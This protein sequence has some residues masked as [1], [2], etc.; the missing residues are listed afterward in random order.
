MSFLWVGVLIGV[1]SLALSYFLPGT[2]LKQL[3]IQEISLSQQRHPLGSHHIFPLV[4][5]PHHEIT[6]KGW[7]E[8]LTNYYQDIEALLDQHQAILFRNF[9]ISSA[10]DFHEMVEATG[11]PSMDY[12]GG[13][14]VRKQ[15]T[16]R[17]VSSNESPPSE[18]IPFH[19]EMA[20]TPHPP[21][22]G[23][24]LILNPQ[25]K[26]LICDQYYSLVKSSQTPEEKHLY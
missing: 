22:H 13:A 18:V 21:T 2:S 6:L 10:Q 26:Y 23:E 24:N 15:F 14:A 4:L 1:I 11:L 5:K 16:S 20:Q 19:H 25:C 9:P 12:I 3:M 17:I 7:I 8:W